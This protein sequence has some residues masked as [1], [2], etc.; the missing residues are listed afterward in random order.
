M[1]PT[2]AFVKCIG[3]GQYSTTS[4][5]TEMASTYETT[6]DFTKYGTN[7]KRRIKYNSTTNALNVCSRMLPLQSH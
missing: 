1:R 6:I 3:L 4:R 2:T 5:V 7:Y